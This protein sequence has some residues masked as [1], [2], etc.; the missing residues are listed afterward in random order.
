[1]GLGD[2]NPS[3]ERGNCRVSIQ[4][5]QPSSW[6][7]L[8]TFEGTVQKKKKSVL[9]NLR[10]DVDIERKE[11]VGDCGSPSTERLPFRGIEGTSYPLFPRKTRSLNGLRAQ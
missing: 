11:T 8:A 2:S 5:P 6:V 10:A 1:M 9:V 3:S 4:I 7:A